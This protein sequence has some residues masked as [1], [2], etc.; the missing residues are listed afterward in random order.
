MRPARDQARDMRHVEDVN[1]AHLVGNLPHP[2]KIPQPRIGARPA[3][4]RL[5]LLALR[6]RLQLVVVDHLRVAPH[7]VKRRPIQLPA[8]AQLVPMRQVPAVR[9]VQPQN[10]VA[11]LQHRHIRRRIGLRARVRLHIRMLR[12]KNLL[13]AVARQVLHHVG[14]FAPAVVASSRIALRIFIGEHRSRRLQHRLRDEVLAGNH[15]QP[16]MLAKRFVVNGCGNFR[17]G[18]GKGKSHAVSHTLNFTATPA[19]SSL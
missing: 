4:N 3:D 19:P 1:R 9:Q 16:F 10:R 2:R 14:I 13:R 5:R 17:I 11:R 15:L 8:E 18:L 6:N 7:R 12:P